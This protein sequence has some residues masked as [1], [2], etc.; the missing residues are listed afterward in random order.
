MRMSRAGEL[1]RQ[2]SFF[3]ALAVREAMRL[4]GRR[5]LCVFLMIWRRWGQA[6]QWHDLTAIDWL[7]R[8]MCFYGPP[9]E[10]QLQQSGGSRW[11][12]C[13]GPPGGNPYRTHAAFPVWLAD[14]WAGRRLAQ[15]VSLLGQLWAL[16]RTV[17]PARLRRHGDTEAYELAQVRGILARYHVPQ[18]RYEPAAMAAAAPPATA[19]AGG[20]YGGWSAL[21]LRLAH[22]YALTPTAGRFLRIRREERAD[23]LYAAGAHRL[24]IRAAQTWAAIL[25]RPP[26]AMTGHADV[27]WRG[28]AGLGMYQTMMSEVL[29]MLF[30]A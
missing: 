7:H 23:S 5:G 24:L 13:A 17:N 30:D 2:A 25:L 19:P 6:L 15:P 14:V 1:G 22:R 18:A 20:P 9:W 28:G 4:Q 16:Y 8:V 11:A 29:R 10:L 12:V 21:C 27:L 3:A 26:T